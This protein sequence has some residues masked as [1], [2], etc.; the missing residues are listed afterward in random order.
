MANNPGPVSDKGKELASSV[1]H[2]ASDV[3]DKAKEFGAAAA[4]Q[5][6]ETAS[7][8]ADKAK[9][10]ASQAG[11]RADDAAASVGGG[12]KSLAGQ[13]R[14]RGPHEGLLGSAASGAA[15]ALER[16]GRYLQEE[17]VTGMAE[18]LTNLIRRNPIPAMLVGIGIGFLFARL[19]SRR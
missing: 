8:L 12:M 19:T 17:G 13:V 7:S 11:Q 14:E 6:K 16:G 5:A 3:K 10:F 9:D 4:H 2:A 15:N 1:G 18:D